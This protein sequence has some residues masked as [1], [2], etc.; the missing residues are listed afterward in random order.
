MVERSLSLPW[1][2]LLRIA[3]PN[4]A[5]GTAGVGYFLSTLARAVNASAPAN[6][7]GFLSASIRGAEYLLSIANTTGGRCLIEHDSE[8]PGLYYLVSVVCRGQ[9][10]SFSFTPAP[11]PVCAGRVQWALRHRALLPAPPR[12]DGRLA[13]AGRGSRRRQGRHG[14]LPRQPR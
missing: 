4:Y 13:L 1:A 7:S 5:E 12:A 11:L 3:V 9:P 6:A 8:T 2:P 10:F 14:P